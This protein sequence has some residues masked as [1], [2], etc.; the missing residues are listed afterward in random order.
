MN[1]KILKILI[2]TIVLLVGIGAASA[3]ESNSSDDAVAVDQADEISVDE[4]SNVANVEKSN[5]ESDGDVLALSDNDELSMAADEDKLASDDSSDNGL[6]YKTF[7]V[8]KL[9]VSKKYAKL[10]P[11]EKKIDK[12]KKN[13]K[14]AKTLYKETHANKF[15]KK[16]KKLKVKYKN[17]VKNYKK[18][19]K[20]FKKAFNKQMDPLKSQVVYITEKL[21]RSNW[22]PCSKANANAVIKGK[23]MVFIFKMKF[24]RGA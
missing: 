22:K 21:A 4:A 19:A 24:C 15:K 5:D 2:A 8:G 18:L 11:M 13:I 20:E 7:A 6:E 23:Y 3:M 10:I 17:Y 14:K 12:Y 1:K 9:K 16:V